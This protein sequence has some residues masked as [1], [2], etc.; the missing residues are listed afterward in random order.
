MVLVLGFCNEVVEFDLKGVKCLVEIFFFLVGFFEEF[1]EVM[2][3]LVFFFVVCLLGG[4]V[5]SFLLLWYYFVS[6]LFLYCYCFGEL[7]REIFMEIIVG[8]V[9]L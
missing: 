5:L 6:F 8:G 2:N 3:V 4:L 1:F 7:L 9:F